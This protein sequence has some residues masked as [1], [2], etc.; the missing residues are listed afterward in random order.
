MMRC[1]SVVGLYQYLSLSSSD[2]HQQSY[3]PNSTSRAPM[4]GDLDDI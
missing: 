2:K 1:A 3:P 4:T